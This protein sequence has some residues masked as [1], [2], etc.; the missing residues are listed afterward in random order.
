MGRLM[1]QPLDR[2]RPLWETWLV[3]GLAGGRWALVFKIHHCMVD[4]VAGVDLL[5]VLLDLEPDDAARA[6]AA[7]WRPA[8]RAVG[9]GAG[10]PDAWTRSGRRR[11]RSA[12]AGARRGASTRS[13]IGPRAGSAWRGGLAAWPATSASPPPSSIDGSIGPHR[14]WAH[15]SADFDDVRAV[16]TAFGGTVNDVVLAAVAGGYRDAARSPGGDDPARASSA[17]WCRCR[18]ATTTSTGVPDNRVSVL[19]PATS[20][21]SWTTPS[22]GS[23]WSRSG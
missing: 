15:S 14:A 1:S 9:C 12:P 22:S 7:P 10:S 8:A 18:S 13:R 23:P 20:R 17:R 19:L 21:S 4:G 2:D 11:R 16:R 5:E 3:E 6:G